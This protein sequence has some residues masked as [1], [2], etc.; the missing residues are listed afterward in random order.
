MPPCGTP[1]VGMPSPSIS[2]FNSFEMIKSSDLSLMPNDQI[3][4][5]NLLWF[6]LSK[7]SLNIYIYAMIEA[8]QVYK[9]LKPCF[10]VVSA[11]VRSKTVTMLMKLRFADRF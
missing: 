1:F 5:S 10:R 7:K 3:C 11:S 8:R 4:L 2:A 9:G 6:T